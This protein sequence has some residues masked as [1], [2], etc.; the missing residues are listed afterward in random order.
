MINDD[1]AETYQINRVDHHTKIG[2]DHSFIT[3]KF[4]YENTEAIKYFK[5]LNFWTKQG[6][7]NSLIEEIW[8]KKVE[9]N[10]KWILQQNLK[11]LDKGLS[12]WSRE[13]IG[14]AF[15][16]VKQL[17]KN[18]MELEQIYESNGSDTNR[19]A[20]HKAQAQYTRWLKMKKD[21]LRQKARISWAEEGDSNFKYFYS[22]VKEKRRRSHIYR[23][24]NN[25]GKWIEGNQAI[26]Y[27]AINHFSNNSSHSH[28]D[29]N[30]S[31]LDCVE[32][33]VTEEENNT[34]YEVPE[35][36]MIKNAIFSID[37][38]SSAGPD[39]FNGYQKRRPGIMSLPQ[40]NLLKGSGEQLHHHW[41][42][43]QAQILS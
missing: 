42:Y 26:S 14:D 20:L 36:T 41:D 1:W 8:N 5:F 9:G 38:N 28:S 40:V 19:Q 32:P 12:K 13:A 25:Q 35:E 18:T 21:I 10:P 37:P 4:G 11:A 33:L 30:F 2:S 29:N 27:A 7:Y 43:N 15:S 6:D 39:D 23:I 31:I 22:V 16:T 17:E 3:F 34:L 24:K